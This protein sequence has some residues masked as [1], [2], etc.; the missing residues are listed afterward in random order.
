[1]KKKRTP[2]YNGRILKNI[3]NQV[4][5]FSM[6]EAMYV[7]SKTLSGTQSYVLT[8]DMNGSQLS[9]FNMATTSDISSATTDPDGNIYIVSDDF[10][11]FTGSSI[12]K[13]DA[14][15]NFITSADGTAAQDAFIKYSNGYIYISKD[16]NLQKCDLNLRTIWGASPST[17]SLQTI[18]IDNSDNV[19]AASDKRLY[20]FNSS[21]SLIFSKSTN[22]SYIN[23]I[24]V[25]S[26][27]DIIF[28]GYGGTTASMATASLANWEKYSSTGAL[29]S[30]GFIGASTSATFS[31][32]IDLITDENNYVYVATSN[33]SGNLTQSNKL[34]VY[35]SSMALQYQYT[36][37]LS[38]QQ[39]GNQ[40]FLYNNKLYS[41]GNINSNPASYSTPG[42]I[43]SD[44]P[45]VNS[46][47]ATFSLPYDNSR[48]IY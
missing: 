33:L 41:F 29:I 1:M 38:G 25:L 17:N 14:Y 24:S 34:Q 8:Y 36:T 39:R 9:Y 43:I 26:N 2:N 44:Y 40:M 31:A 18:Y 20:K 35:N 47:V 37:Y 45:D 30:N 48:I 5:Y 32:I 15:G 22:I 10:V 6:P 4:E 42:V 13:Y 28:G 7:Y 27:N 16:N 23:A 19:Y 11:L 46:G 12:D 21:G 3:N